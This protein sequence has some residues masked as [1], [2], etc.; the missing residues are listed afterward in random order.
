MQLTP[1]IDKLK[2]SDGQQFAVSIR[3]HLPSRNWLLEILRIYYRYLIFIFVLLAS[4]LSR[5]LVCYSS[6]RRSSRW[7]T[8]YRCLRSPL[9]SCCLACVFKDAHPYRIFPQALWDTHKTAWQDPLMIQEPHLWGVS[10]NQASK[11]VRNPRSRTW[12]PPPLKTATV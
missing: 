6:I 9:W 2:P 12:R 7:S 1:D 5:T 8:Q 3:I 10:N 11:V 4:W